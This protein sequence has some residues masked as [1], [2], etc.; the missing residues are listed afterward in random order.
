MV[1]PRAVALLSSSA[2]ATCVLIGS[3]L[4]KP[5][6]TLNEIQT[7]HRLLRA[8]VK[9]D[10]DE[11][12]RLAA[13]DEPSPWMIAE[14]LLARGRPEV[15]EALA[16]A[17]PRPL[18]RGLTEYVRRFRDKTPP[19][20]YTILFRDIT[21]AATRHQWDRV[22]ALAD[23]YKGSFERISGIVV[24]HFRAVAHY[25]ASR[26]RESA[27]FA[28]EKAKASEAIGWHFMAATSYAA[29]TKNLTQAGELVAPLR[30]TE[31]WVR[32][33]R[34]LGDVPTRF[35]W[36]FRESH[37]LATLSDLQQ[38]LGR[39]EAAWKSADAA[40]ALADREDD[41]RNAAMA[42][43]E[44]GVTASS[45]GR[46]EEART[47]LARSRA[48]YDQAGSAYTRVHARLSLSDVVDRLGDRPAARAHLEDGARLAG[49][50]ADAWHRGQA[51]RLLAG[52][53]HGVGEPERAVELAQLALDILDRA[54]DVAGVA[55]ALE[56]L[57]GWLESLGR[58][59]E[60]LR[61]ARRS[62]ELAR[63]HKYARLE[64]EAL[65][66]LAEIYRTRGDPGR[67]LALYDNAAKLAERKGEL[68]SLRAEIALTRSSLLMHFGRSVDALKAAEHGHALSS[69]QKNPEHRASALLA[70]ADV[71]SQL[72]DYGRSK[73]LADE[74][75]RIRRRIGS[76]GSLAMAAGASGMAY[77]RVGLHEEAIA[78]MEEALAL[79]EESGDPRALG[80]RL[81]N[82]GVV[83]GNAGLH[84]KSLEA[85]KRARALRVKLKDPIGIM[86]LDHNIGRRYLIQERIQEA[87]PW[88][89]R[90]T[91]AA[92]RLRD[93]HWELVGLTALMV[94]RI[95]SGEPKKAL[96][97][98][99]R[100]LR[101]QESLAAGLD[102]ELGAHARQRYGRLY[103]LGAHAAARI[104]DVKIALRYLEAGRAGGLLET[105][106]GRD[107]VDWDAASK[108]LREEE[109]N[110]KEMILRARAETARGVRHN[111]LEVVRA[112]RRDL[113]KG[114][115]ALAAVI[116]RMQREAKREAGLLYPPPASAQQLGEALRKDEVLIVYGAADGWVLSVMIM[117]ERVTLSRFATNV[118]PL[119]A[120]C[121]K[122]D[123]DDPGLDP[124]KTL[125]EI[126]KL[127][128]DPIELPEGTKRVIVSPYGP[129]CY[130]PF[131]LLFDVPVT[132]T[133]SATTHMLLRQEDVD[134]GI[135]RLALG[136]PDYTGATSKAAA[137]YHRGR[138]LRPLP[139]SEGEAKAI[140]TTT[141][142]GSQANEEALRRAL[143]GSTRLRALH[144]A[145]HG[146][147]DLERSA[148]SSLALSATKDSDGF[149]T[150]S[151]VLRMKIP[152]DLVA[153]SACETGTGKIMKGEG[154]LGLTRAFMY[155]GAPR[156]LCSLWKVD[157]EATQALMVKFYELWDPKEGKG[158]G[159]AEALKQA[160][161]HVRGH[162]KWKHPYYWAAWV[163][164]GLPE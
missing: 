157:D 1:F 65:V 96:E 37:A 124:D 122:L 20:H 25:E 127:I 56:V 70:L 115:K 85:Y 44:R 15:A 100:A 121:E 131:S 79:V 7:S 105:L 111:D 51:L 78:L 156:V 18:T 106:G 71:Y 88:L 153:L 75:L 108:S 155:A 152:A 149:L 107:V 119:A 117:P 67:A 161:G 158:I 112:A 22:L 98:G 104:P 53:F 82:L 128:V 34:A 11:F 141:L 14:L 64:A 21:R 43:A 55:S 143:E 19:E 94:A 45:L 159:A 81:A 162:E 125:S 50:I 126:R 148:L 133:P 76:P 74:A 114:E 60:A 5:D 54:E 110:A 97:L 31:G 58:R 35:K 63:R 57:A 77:S 91:A 89:E 132:M 12:A 146:L 40:L 52:H 109:E 36:S 164:W 150:G 30:T 145:C 123:L 17:A 139:A 38:S 24:T 136:A 87:L 46:L 27:E 32:N 83:Y 90:S 120:L 42:L 140:G 62:L 84:E 73:S 26:L 41:P 99:E 147:I 118:E 2:L 3:A 8:F 69:A 86:T 135:G 49:D 9:G 10:K 151:E 16:A 66:T 101:L 33:V 129:L 113:E 6:G 48:L 138:P 68:T 160:Q 134:R 47:D 92:V 13:R 39:Y 102:E 163:L 61:A 29:A 4:A 142:L 23:T 154:I 72:G 103:E 130:V 93:A 95:K 80:Y 116:A 144:L 59:R 137:V 28:V